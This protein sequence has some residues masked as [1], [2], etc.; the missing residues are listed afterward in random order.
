MT[1]GLVVVLEAIDLFSS[2]LMAAWMRRS[3]V[4]LALINC[5]ALLYANIAYR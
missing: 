4:K 2:A 1:R 3:I 5:S